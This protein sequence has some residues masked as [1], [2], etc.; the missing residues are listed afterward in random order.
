MNE[1]VKD[2]WFPGRWLGGF[3]LIV[4]PIF[5]LI[6]VILRSKFHFFFPDQLEAYKAHPTLL[7]F[8]YSFFIAGNVLLW[9][10]VIS[11]C[12]L[13]SIK[14][15]NW[16]LWGGSFA[17]FGLFARTFHAGVD[18]LA[19]QMVRILGVDT[20]TKVMAQTYGAFHIFHSFSPLI[21]FGWI[22]LAIGSYRAKVLG[23]IRSVMLGL[24]SSLPLGVLK[25]TTSFSILATLALCIALV[26]LGIRVLKDGP[27][28]GFKKIIGSVILI[29]ILLVGLFVIG[30]LG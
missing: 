7:F 17:V 12:K 5:M 22:I 25:G 1:R 15:P 16:A 8:S 27:R 11:L 26:P 2:N 19:F 20:A 10:A 29:S 24:M 30:E 18:H 3:S 23:L 9:P 13:I 4:G 21:M 6:G 14:K 28:P